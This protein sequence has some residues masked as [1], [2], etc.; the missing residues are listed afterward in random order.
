M[1]TQLWLEDLKKRDRQLVWHGWKDDIKMGLKERDERLQNVFIL[2][3]IQVS[4]WLL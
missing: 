4:G 3:Q 1:I 2:L